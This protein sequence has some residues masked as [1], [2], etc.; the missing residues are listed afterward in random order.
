MVPIQKTLWNSKALCFGPFIS[1]FII[2]F[3]RG[4]I[5]NKYHTNNIQIWSHLEQWNRFWVI[6]SFTQTFKCFSLAFIKSIL[7]IHRFAMHP[8]QHEIDWDP[9]WRA[10]KIRY[11]VKC[12]GNS[13]GQPTWLTTW[14]N[15]VKDLTTFVE[16]ATKVPF[17]YML[18]RVII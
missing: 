10:T 2:L 3:S 17:K 18:K 6:C 4:L 14:K 7:T 11:L 5:K 9:I 8:L 13:S 15:T 12:V 16:Y 1:V